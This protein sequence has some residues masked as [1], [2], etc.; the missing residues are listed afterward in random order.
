MATVLLSHA[1]NFIQAISPNRLSG[2]I[3]TPSTPTPRPPA[4]AH[5]DSRVQ[6]PSRAYDEELELLSSPPILPTDLPDFLEY[7]HKKG[8]DVKPEP[9]AQLTK[10]KYGPNLLARGDVSIEKL[11][12]FGIPEGDAM[13]LKHKAST[14]TRKRKLEHHRLDVSGR[15]DQRRP[16]PSCKCI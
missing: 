13:E 4:L 1:V 8:I 9:A 10:H 15:H 2:M 12:D 3:S 7:A 16:S 14:F 6:Q 5:H 11:V